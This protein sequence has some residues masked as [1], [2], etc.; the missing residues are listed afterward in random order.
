MR[1]REEE[2]TRSGV[3][4]ETSGGGS[5]EE[6]GSADD[7]T[8]EREMMHGSGRPEV[9]WARRGGAANTGGE[10]TV[11]GQQQQEDGTQGME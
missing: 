3:E 9:G 2:G 6:G 4:S 7:A 8:G 1:R 5:V 10:A 11:G